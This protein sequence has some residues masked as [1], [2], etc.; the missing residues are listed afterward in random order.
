MKNKE[1]C[2][3]YIRVSTAMQVDGYS[4]DAQKDRLVKFAEFQGMEIVREYCDA[5]KSG[6]S[7]TGRP[8]FQK[9]L[10]DVAEDRDGVSYILVFKLS[11]FG[12]NAADV[13]NSLQYIQDY[14]VNL[15]C[16]EDGIDSSKDSGKLTITVLSAVAEIERENILV[17]TMEGRRQKAREGKWNGGQ[18]PFGYLLDSK[19]STL[20]VN[21]E[22]AEIVRL[23]FEKFVHTD[24][25]ADSISKY[26]N[27][28]G[29]SKKKL[30]EQEVTYFTRSTILKILDNPVYAGKIAYGKNTTEKVKGTRDQY[31]RVKQDE[32][33]LADGLHEAI[34]DPETW[35]TAKAKRKVTGIKWNKTH[36][37][38]HEHILSGILKCPVCGSGMA[39]T[40]RRRKNKKTGEYKDDFYYRC[41]HRK[42]IDED[43]FCGFKPS[44]N[45]DELNE[46]VVQI[47]RDMVAMEKFR[48]FIQSKLQEKV[49][50]SS[51]E[52]ER[53]QVK[54][55]LQQVMGAKKKL[56]LMLDKLDVNDRHYERKY[57]DMQERLDNLY[58]RIS[59]LEEM[60]A[61]VEEK[62]SAS[63]GEQITGKQIYQFLLEFDKIYRKM[64]DL[65]K[66]EFMR[67]FIKAIEL[68]PERDDSGRIIKQ[69]SFKFPVYYNGCEGDTIR[70]L[71]EN[72]V[73][74][75]VLLSHKSPDSVINVKVEFGEGDD[76]ISLDCDCRTGEE[77][78]AETEN[79]I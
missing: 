44:L 34:I 16:V 15:I 61:D 74:T 67:T 28:H 10:Q 50:V 47:I 2:Y 25:G 45:Q 73:E 58:D 26:L 31:R 53:E 3:L 6:K 68:Y 21:P 11:R 60:L 5:G 48:D 70:L 65:E 71:N 63:C 59:E 8:E 29:Y 12:R 79:H 72:T 20:I 78:S 14:G 19:N 24:M 36:S 42:K 7:I 27:Q 1:K 13:L 30:R 33:L 37:L 9:M 4:L 77:I 57:Q 22:E 18:A 69:I 49:D 56:V 23:I 52:E 17:Q 43:H 51:L 55:R 64:T 76:K 41:Q 35:E 66:K 54:G 75:V 46:K 40:V 32:Y 62:I 39:G 38:D